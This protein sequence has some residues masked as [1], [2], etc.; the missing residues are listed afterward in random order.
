[1]DEPIVHIRVDTIREQP[2]GS[3]TLTDDQSKRLRAVWQQLSR[4]P[5]L[6]EPGENF[7]RFEAEFSRD[8][9]PEMEIPLWEELAR[10]LAPVKTYGRAKKVHDRWLKES[11]ERTPIGVRPRPKKPGPQT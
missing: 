5:G 10:L 4:F 11:L 7:E 8:L 1:M 9:H 2:V 6:C 3:S